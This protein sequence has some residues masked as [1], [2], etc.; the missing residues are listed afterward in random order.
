MSRS[1]RRPTSPSGRALTKCSAPRTAASA[2][3]RRRTAQA[4]NR[5]AKSAEAAS[6]AVTGASRLSKVGKAAGVVGVAVDGAIRVKSAVET[7][8]K[9][10]AGDLTGEERVTAHAKNASGMAG[11]LGGAW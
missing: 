10:Q 11:G 2:W 5:A 3:S 4:A 7:E 6:M 9:Y 1:S 8:K